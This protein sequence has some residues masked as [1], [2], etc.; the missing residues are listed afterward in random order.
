[1]LRKKTIILG[2]GGNARVLLDCIDQQKYEVIGFLDKDSSTV[3]NMIHSIP[4][5]GD[6][7]SPD[8][9]KSLGIDCCIIGIGH[10][11]NYKIRNKLFDRYKDAGFQMINAV[12]SSSIISASAQI[13]IGNA[14]MPGAIINA[15]A[16]IGDNTII[17]SGTV[18][19]HDVQI[20]NGAHIAPG[21]TLSGAARVGEST[22]V[23]AGSTIIQGISVGAGSIIG[24]GSVVISDIPPNVLALGCPARIIKEI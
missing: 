21:C 8:K 4:V 10:V 17:N 19:E 7:S 13:G 23:G 2:A 20:H 12:H 22:F 6:D 1:M 18:I 24:A 5:I 15:D 11:G 14:I 16:A 9:W 3:G